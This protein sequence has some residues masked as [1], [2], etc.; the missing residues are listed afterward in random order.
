MNKDIRNGRIPGPGAMDVIEVS[1]HADKRQV[2][3]GIKKRYI[4]LCICKGVRFLAKDNASKF[5]YAGLTV[6]TN[7]TKTA[8]ITAYWVEENCSICY[9]GIIQFRSEQRRN[10]CERVREVRKNSRDFKRE[11]VHLKFRLKY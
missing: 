4:T 10:H 5:V 6:I 3:R 7:L 2:Q 1:K 9:D 8:I 11:K